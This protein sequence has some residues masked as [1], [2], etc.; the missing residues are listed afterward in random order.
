MLGEICVLIKN[1]EMKL[2]VLP[3]TGLTYKF[4]MYL[5]LVEV[6]SDLIHLCITNR[7]LTVSLVGECHPPKVFGCRGRSKARTM[8]RA[9]LHN[10]IP[11][12]RV[13]AQCVEEFAALLAIVAWESCSSILTSYYFLECIRGLVRLAGRFRLFGV[14]ILDSLATVRRSRLFVIGV[15]S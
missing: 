2:C 6:V 7:L 3:I 9:L 13:I 5:S 10:S 8:T 11:E 4:Y 1:Q 15:S 12:P 14:R